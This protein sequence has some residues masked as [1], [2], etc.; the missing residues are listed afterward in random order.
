M[1]KPDFAFIHKVSVRKWLKQGVNGPEYADAEL[2]RCR[3]N[4]S[5]K[6]VRQTATGQDIIASGSAWFSAG[7][8]MEPESLIEFDGR[9]YS[10]LS[11]LPCY[12]FYGENHVEVEIK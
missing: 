4:F 5:R 8:R 2:M 12:D 7:T 9:T 11:C 3:L 1:L 10:V 6:K